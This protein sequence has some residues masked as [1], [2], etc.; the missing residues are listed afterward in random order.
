MG[1]SP[2][3]DFTKIQKRAGIQEMKLNRLLHIISLFSDYGKISIH[4]RDESGRAYH[5]EFQSYEDGDV[6]CTVE[7]HDNYRTFAFSQ[8]SIDRHP[9]EYEF[10]KEVD[11]NINSINS[12]EKRVLIKMVTT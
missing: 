4:P 6:G 2:V 3:A 8:S 10:V 7:T 9:K 12:E 5:I 1:A 11:I